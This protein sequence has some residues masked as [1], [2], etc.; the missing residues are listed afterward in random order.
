[1]VFSGRANTTG[2]YPILNEKTS[3]NSLSPSLLIDATFHQPQVSYE[4]PG[5]VNNVSVTENSCIAPVKSA[6]SEI[7]NL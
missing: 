1:L 7:N 6:L 2:E 4:K 3:E 5:T